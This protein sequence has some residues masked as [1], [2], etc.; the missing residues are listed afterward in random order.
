MATPIETT[1]PNVRIRHEEGCQSILACKSFYQ[2]KLQVYVV[3]GFF[4][5]WQSP[6]YLILN[7]VNR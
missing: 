2:F 5:P 3:D 1:S 4:L 7:N 6:I